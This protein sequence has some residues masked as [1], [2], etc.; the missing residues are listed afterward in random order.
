MNWTK[1]KPTRSGYYWHK[2]DVDYAPA[3]R[4]VFR[5]TREELRASYVEHAGS[6][7]LHSWGGYWCGPIEPPEFK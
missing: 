6:R 3:I 2:H 4:L 1:E 5:G 7:S